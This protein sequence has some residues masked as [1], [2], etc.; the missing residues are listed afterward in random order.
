MQ[1]TEELWFW[2]EWSKTLKAC[3][4]KNHKALEG[5]EDP[6]L[7]EERKECVEIG[8]ICNLIIKDSERQVKYFLP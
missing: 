2:H 6:G 4:R 3:G 8:S 5:Q 1:E 7:I